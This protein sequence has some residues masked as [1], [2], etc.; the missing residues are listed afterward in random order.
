MKG[1]QW[2]LVGCVSGEKAVEK[3]SHEADMAKKRL[4]VGLW[5]DSGSKAC[6]KSFWLSRGDCPEDTSAAQASMS[7]SG[8]CVCGI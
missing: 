7:G 8:L 2:S 4:I 1:E 5:K 3:R 6:R